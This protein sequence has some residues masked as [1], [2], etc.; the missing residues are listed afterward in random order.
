M[1]ET[2]VIFTGFFSAFAVALGFGVVYNSARIAL[3]ERGRELASLRVLGFSRA[4]ISY[5]LLGEVAVLVRFE[6]RDFRGHGISTDITEAGAL[7]F[8]DV[9]NRVLR[10]RERNARAAETTA[11]LAAG[12]I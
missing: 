12:S 4:G 8:L 6:D 10:A 5:I 2:I 7:A 1:A 3:S 9:I 11:S